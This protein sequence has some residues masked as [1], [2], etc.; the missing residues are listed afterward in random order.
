M[1]KILM[2]VAVLGMAAAFTACD[3]CADNSCKTANDS[4]STAYGEYVGSMIN[5]DFMRFDNHEK[6]DKE[7]FL[8]GMQIVFGADDSKNTQMG[9][10]V[11][12][13]LSGELAQMK[14]QGLEVDRVAVMNAFK[15]AFLNDSVDY[16]QLSVASDQFRM[17]YQR[18]IDEAQATKEAEKAA[19]GEVDNI[20]A[21]QEYVEKF[22]AENPEAKTTNNGLTYLIETEGEAPTPAEDA[23][24]VVNYTGKHINGEVFDSTDGRGP[25]TFNLQG[26]VPGFREGLMLLGKGGKATLVIPGSLAYGPNGAGNDIQ[27]NETL[28]FDVELLDIQ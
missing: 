27:P 15:A 2:G 23:T 20:K 16:G 17:L 1:K 3:K 28:I 13:Q 22:K 9:M 5:A 19:A 11:A 10:Q 7:A 8:R 21:G 6:S 25:A 18:A 14:Q 12:L 4:L 24:V 26:V